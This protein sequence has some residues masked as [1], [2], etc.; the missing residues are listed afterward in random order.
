[1]TPRW[2]EAATRHRL[3]AARQR[4]PGSRK[5]CCWGRME[6]LRLTRDLSPISRPVSR[7]L[8]VQAPRAR[9]PLSAP[10]QA[11]TLAGVTG[12]DLATAD[13]AELI[14]RALAIGDTEDDRYWDVVRELQRRGDTPTFEAASALCA[15]PTPASRELELDVLAQ[16]GYTIGRPY[17][18]ETLPIVFTL[19]SAEEPKRVLTSAI[20]A[21]GH[22]YDTRAQPYL[23]E[24][25][26]H[27]DEDVRFAVAQALPNVVGDP[28]SSEVVDALTTL[29]RDTDA[30]VRD[31]ATFALGSIVAIDTDGVREALLARIDDPDGDTSGEALVGL[32]TRGE[33]RIVDRVLETPRESRRGQP[34]CRGCWETPRPAVSASALSAQGSRVGKRGRAGLVARPSDRRL[35]TSRGGARRSPMDAS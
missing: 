7:T 33:R 14:K 28:P 3:P 11:S 21:L 4:P 19:G 10:E 5:S 20:C 9:A 12:E 22:L 29:T 25:A 26:R 15:A 1:M 18:E 30:D 17:L 8:T 2:E 34:D 6:V 24:N 27:P 23:L 35:R 32:A 13:V 16:L 31:W